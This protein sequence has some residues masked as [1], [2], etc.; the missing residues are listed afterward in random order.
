MRANG[1]IGTTVYGRIGRRVALADSVKLPG[2]RKF[3]LQA[4]DRRR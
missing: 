1:R 4:V 2:G 3:R